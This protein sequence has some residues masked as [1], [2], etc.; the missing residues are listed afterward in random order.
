MYPLP[1][2]ETAPAYREL[3]DAPR[4]TFMW[5]NGDRLLVEQWVFA[6]TEVDPAF[7]EVVGTVHD[8]VSALPETEGVS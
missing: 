1:R 5:T 3:D 7:D 8:T 4:P 2:G 6:H